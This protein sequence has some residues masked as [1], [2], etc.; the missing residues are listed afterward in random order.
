MLDEKD[1]HIVDPAQKEKVRTEDEV[2]HA[3][4]ERHLV[5]VKSHA[6][7][8]DVK[9]HLISDVGSWNEGGREEEC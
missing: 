1:E 6:G 5:D 4:P 8:H 3:Q 7:H 2:D 9:Q